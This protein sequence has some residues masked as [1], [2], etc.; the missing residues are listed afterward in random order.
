MKRTVSIDGEPIKRQKHFKKAKSLNKVTPKALKLYVKK[1]ILQQA[2]KKTFVTYAANQPI[3]TAGAVTVPFVVYLPPISQGGG[4][5][6][7]VG[8][9]VRVV[10][11]KL[12]LLLNLFCHIM[13]ALTPV[14]APIL[15][16]VM[17]VQSIIRNTDN[18]GITNILTDFFTTTGATTGFQ[19]NPLDIVLPINDESWKIFYDNTV[20]LG[21][22]TKRG[23]STSNDASRYV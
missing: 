17:I 23:S 14:N 7:R 15:C 4:D 19:G 2:E 3:T 20:K 21:T 13:S 16:R 1:A 10:D 22:T 6:Q 18:I 11:Q 8:N 9:R 5:G 12:K